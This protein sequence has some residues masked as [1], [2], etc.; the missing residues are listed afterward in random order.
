M[1]QALQSIATPVPCSQGTG[2]KSQRQCSKVVEWLMWVASKHAQN[3]LIVV[4]HASMH[5]VRTCPTSKHNTEN[6]LVA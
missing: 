3:K 4:I 6:E 2:G 5:A 1:V